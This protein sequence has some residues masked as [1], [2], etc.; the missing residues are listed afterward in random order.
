M[1][2]Q[3]PRQQVSRQVQV[4]KAVQLPQLRRDRTGQMTYFRLC[5]VVRHVLP[6]QPLQYPLQGLPTVLLRHVRPQW[7]RM[8]PHATHQFQVTLDSP[9][10]VGYVPA[11]PP[12]G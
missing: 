11:I 9:F 4:T 1:Q 5:Q 8:A 10:G 6:V 12:L 3:G 2:G 7:K